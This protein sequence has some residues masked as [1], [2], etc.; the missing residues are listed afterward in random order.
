MCGGGVI[1][2]LAEQCGAGELISGDGVVGVYEECVITGSATDTDIPACHEGAGGPGVDHSAVLAPGHVQQQV[3]ADAEIGLFESDVDEV[4]SGTQ[5]N[6]E[7]A[8]D[9]QIGFELQSQG[10]VT[11]TKADGNTA[12]G[13]GVG[14]G[15]RNGVGGLL[16]VDADECSGG[17]ATDGDTFDAELDSDEV[18]V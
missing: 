5:V 10:V 7:V 15:D 14:E 17:P 4:C 2:Q 1:D 18:A 8:G 11:A 12:D 9:C 6:S 13:G 3:L 16:A